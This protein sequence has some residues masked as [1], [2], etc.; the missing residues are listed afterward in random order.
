MNKN[1]VFLN[2]KMTSTRSRN[3]KKEII[4]IG[5]VKLTKEFEL[6]STFSRFIKV[7]GSELNNITIAK[8]TATQEDVNNS[9][10]FLTTYDA[11]IKWTGDLDENAFIFWGKYD[12]KMLQM[13]LNKK[14]YTGESRIK[15]YFNYQSYLETKVGSSLSL[16]DAMKKLGLEVEGTLRNA[17]DYATNMARVYQEAIKTTDV[18]KLWFEG[19]LVRIN[20]ELEETKEHI[21]KNEKVNF[22]MYYIDEL[23][24]QCKLQI[25]YSGLFTKEEREKKL[26]HMRIH[27][28]ELEARIEDV[29]MEQFKKESMVVQWCVIKKSIH[30]SIG[31]VDGLVSKWTELS[32]FY[33]FFNKNKRGTYSLHFE[34]FKEFYRSLDRKK[35]NFIASQRQTKTENL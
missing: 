13:E 18:N 35:A 17:C 28:D 27:L 20:A 12:Y 24:S 23:I 25:S 8:T 16:A 6:I 15:K 5:A 32:D 2:V 31:S 30:E 22:N 4:Q 34:T 14:G 19:K 21:S 3:E 9:E 29:V 7:E 10:S 1:L 26:K 33:Q 11:L